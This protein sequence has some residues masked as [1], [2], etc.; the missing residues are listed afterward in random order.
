MLHLFT[1]NSSSVDFSPLESLRRLFT[2]CIKTQSLY[3]D[4]RCGDLRLCFSFTCF[5]TLLKPMFPSCSVDELH[6]SFKIST[7]CFTAM[8]PRCP[9]TAGGN[10]RF[11]IILLTMA[12]GKTRSVTFST[13]GRIPCRKSSC[14]LRSDRSAGPNLCD[15]VPFVQHLSSGKCVRCVHTFVVH[16]KVTES[17][18][19]DS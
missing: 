4:R 10:S 8:Y 13:C 6:S 15:L 16:T 1:G 18:E 19:L 2:P 5:M 11:K 12:S 7:N 9:F 14:G 17:C 3:P